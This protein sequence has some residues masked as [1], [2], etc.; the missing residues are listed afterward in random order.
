MKQIKFNKEIFIEVANIKPRS[1][2]ILIFSGLILFAIISTLFLWNEI[3]NFS[4]NKT[5]DH[6]KLTNYF[7]TIF[8]STG[9]LV[10]IY[11]TH[12]Q[13]RKAQLE[14]QAEVR[15]DLHPMP[16]SLNLEYELNLA[17]NNNPTLT[18][19]SVCNEGLGKAE[20]I[21]ITWNWDLKLVETLCQTVF[22]GLPFEI[23]GP[24]NRFSFI[25][26]KESVQID[27]PLSYFSLFGEAI[28]LKSNSKLNGINEKN[29]IICPP[30]ILRMRYHDILGNCYTKSYDVIVIRRGKMA[31]VSFVNQT[32]FI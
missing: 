9:A 12:L 2:K 4:I 16:F 19:L 25:H 31:N 30:L 1:Y 22:E 6:E 28:G 23:Q 20:Q 3:K 17:F 10:T 29:G 21:T 15:P 18:F 26:H 11:L 14:K 7:L 8:T 27:L 32:G 5:I 24:S 13:L